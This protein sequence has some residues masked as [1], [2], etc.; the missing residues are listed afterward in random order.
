MLLKEIKFIAH[1]AVVI[2]VTTLAHATFYIRHVFKNEEEGG[3]RGGQCGHF[4]HIC[5]SMWVF[6]RVQVGNGRAC[7]KLLVDE[8][9]V[10]S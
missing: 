2:C 1:L 10:S 4:H 8:S 6:Y 7:A 5:N 9:V 3:G